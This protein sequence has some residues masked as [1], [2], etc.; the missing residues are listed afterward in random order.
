M[1]IVF[2]VRILK[3]HIQIRKVQFQHY[4]TLLSLSSRYLD[5]HLIQDSGK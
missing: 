5:I 2:L 4:N 3:I 1:E